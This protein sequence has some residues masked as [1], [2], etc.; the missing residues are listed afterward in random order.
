M[1]FRDN[2]RTIFPGSRGDSETLD[3][4]IDSVSYQKPMQSIFTL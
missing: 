4:Y 1:S 3:V 2:G